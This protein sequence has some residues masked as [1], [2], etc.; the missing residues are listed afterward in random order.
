MEIELLLLYYV[1][2]FYLYVK[3]GN[4]RGNYHMITEVRLSRQI[5]PSSRSA[6][7]HTME[8]NNGEKSC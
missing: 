2:L 3:R 4:N 6:T 7:A 8:F 1:L 5:V